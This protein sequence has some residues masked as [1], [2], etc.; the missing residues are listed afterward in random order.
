MRITTPYE[1]ISQ[2]SSCVSLLFRMRVPSPRS[3]TQPFF[4]LVRFP[5]AALVLVNRAFFGWARSLRAPA[6]SITTLAS[7]AAPFVPT[8]FAQTHPENLPDPP[9]ITVT[10]VSASVSP[11]NVTSPTLAHGEQTS[12]L[13]SRRRCTC[14]LAT[15]ACGRSQGLPSLTDTA[16]PDRSQTS[17]DA[18]QHPTPA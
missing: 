10:T 9:S 15:R 16:E 12:N 14:P 8:N 11:S 18:F 7:T 6:L 1:D 4:P 5:R 2:L 13:V 17:V 3:L